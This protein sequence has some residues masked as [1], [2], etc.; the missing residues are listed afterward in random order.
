MRSMIE[1][2]LAI[3]NG[4]EVTFDE[5][6]LACIAYSCMLHSAEIELR[7]LAEQVM[8]EQKFLMRTK[9]GAAIRSA[10]TRFDS[11]KMPVDKYLGPSWTPGTPENAAMRKT[12]DA[13]LA[14]FAGDPKTNPA[15][16]EVAREILKDRKADNA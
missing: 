2:S 6:K 10:S 3:E 12:S 4:K 15:S 14:K 1:I 5:A 9:A 7:N 16:A 11:R 13:I 8:T